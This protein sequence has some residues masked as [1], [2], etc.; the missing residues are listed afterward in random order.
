[1]SIESFSSFFMSPTGSAISVVILLVL[2]AFFALNLKKNNTLSVKA[3]T[4]CAICI[5]LATVLS[6]V[7]LF[8]MP[9]AQ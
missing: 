4:Y 7:K 2:V 9:A 8:K 1:M 3:L 5:A 6:N